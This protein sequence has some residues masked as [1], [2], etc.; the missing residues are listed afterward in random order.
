MKALEEKGK[1]WDLWKEMAGGTGFKMVQTE[2]KGLKDRLH[3]L[4]VIRKD[5]GRRDE[6]Y[7]CLDID[8]LQ[9]Y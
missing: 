5:A 2:L 4:F 7:A 6:V 9:L 1:N 3:S 8:M